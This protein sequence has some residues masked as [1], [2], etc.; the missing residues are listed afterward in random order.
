M[1]VLTPTAMFFSPAVFSILLGATLLVFIWARIPLRFP[2]STWTPLLLFLAGTLIA[3]AV[4]P[5]PL[6]SWPQVKKFWVLLTLAILYSAVRQSSDVYRMAGLW[7]L[8]GGVAALW[9]F[10]QFFEKWEAASRAHA[11]FYAAYIG[12][13]VTGLRDHWMTFSGEQMIVVLIV[14]ALFLFGPKTRQWW[15]LALAFA[16]ISASLV[17]SLTRGVWVATVVGLAYLIGVWRW[18]LLPLLPVTLMVVALASPAAVRE[19]IVSFYSAHGDLDSNMFR[20]YVWRTGLEMVRAHPWLGLGPSEVA[21]Q[22]DAYMPPDLPKKKP[23]GF[24]GHL[25]NIY[26]EYAAERGIPTLAALLWFILGSMFVF[27]RALRALPPGRGVARFV[28]HSGVAVT[29]AILTEGFSEANLADSEI[30]AMYLAV[31]A[32]AFIVINAQSAVPGTAA[33]ATAA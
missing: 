28:L 26:L 29:L 23:E 7:A 16:L 1:A 24:Y 22:F 13:R 5:H 25:H 31:V 10:V 27:I 32:M 17:I 12:A 15:W 20:V 30:L 9:S 8:F 19:R 11:N 18:R 3:V 2:R 14:V 4:S 21:K 6:A 33:P